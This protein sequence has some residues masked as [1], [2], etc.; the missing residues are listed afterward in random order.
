M[1]NGKEK[2]EFYVG[3]DKPEILEGVLVMHRTEWM[4]FN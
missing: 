2:I 3:Q 4:Y 1:T